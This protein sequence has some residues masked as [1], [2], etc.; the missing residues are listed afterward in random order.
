MTNRREVME[1]AKHQRDAAVDNVMRVYEALDYYV[2]LLLDAEDII[3]E[4]AKR[5]DLLETEL[6]DLED[7]VQMLH[8]K[9][10]ELG[11]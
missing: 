5:I 10:V 4:Q 6:G 2:D 7:E 3:E 8:E 11:G 1:A 9:V